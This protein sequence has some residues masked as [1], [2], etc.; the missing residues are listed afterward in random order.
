M[1][2]VVRSLRA[3]PWQTPRFSGWAVDV[4]GYDHDPVVELDVRDMVVA[5]FARLPNGEGT[6]F[7]VVGLDVDSIAD[8]PE[9]LLAAIEALGSDPLRNVVKLHG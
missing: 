2:E 4:G 5:D 8:G 9:R 3:W 7:L 1:T 6:T